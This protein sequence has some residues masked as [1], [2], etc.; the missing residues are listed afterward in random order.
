M[1]Y[2]DL[3]ETFSQTIDPS[4]TNHE[5][6]PILSTKTAKNSK[7]YQKH[8]VYRVIEALKKDFPATAVLLEERNF[9]FFVFQFLKNQP[10]ESGNIDDL[11]L[12]FKSFLE[13]RE[14][15]KEIVWLKDI[16]SL[17][18]LWSRANTQQQSLILAAGALQLWQNLIDKDELVV[19]VRS[20]QKEMVSLI[21]EDGESYLSKT[22]L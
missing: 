5:L 19:P 15:L 21:E 18:F 1:K 7:V 2:K 16:L 8:L 20:E 12:P 4:Q 6:H 22:P 17:D 3:I 11:S 10:L 13:A 14:A 9:Q